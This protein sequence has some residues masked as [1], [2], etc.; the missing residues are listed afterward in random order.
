MAIV[1]GAVSSYVYPA[2]E[3]RPRR[4]PDAAGSARMALRAG[5]ISLVAG[6][7]RR[8]PAGL[9]PALISRFFPQ[10]AASIPAV[11]WSL[12]AGLLVEP[13][14]ATQVLGSLK[15]WP[16]LA[17]YIGL[18]LAHALDFPLGPVGDVRAPRGRGPRQRLGR[19]DHGGRSPSGSFEARPHRPR[20]AKE[21]AA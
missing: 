2:D 21:V 19:G 1:P 5:A 3:L 7:P 6:L 15:A 18:L 10:Y 14:P 11:R 17:I 8:D 16:R 12:F 4:G 20:V 9:A 13:F